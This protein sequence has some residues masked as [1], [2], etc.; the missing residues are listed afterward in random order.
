MPKAI[1]CKI[2]E[3]EA[4]LKRA[5]IDHLI[6]S[7]GARIEGDEFFYIELSQVG[8]L[9][10]QAGYFAGEDPNSEIERAD[11]SPLW[12]LSVG[13]RKLMGYKTYRET[14]EPFMPSEDLV[15][16]EGILVR[17]A[18]RKGFT[19]LE[20]KRVLEVWTEFNGKAT[21]KELAEI[22][23]M[24]EESARKTIGR[25][26]KKLGKPKKLWSIRIIQSAVELQKVT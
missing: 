16:D 25:M 11:Q 19:Q 23:Q 5:Q 12:A 15:N 3:V 20:I 1:R 17:F 6:R 26:K 13:L 10:Q 8:V 4:V 22:W 24:N 2:A 14:L 21:F 7:W 18:Q 9:W